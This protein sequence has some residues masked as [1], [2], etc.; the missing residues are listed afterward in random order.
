MQFRRREKYGRSYF[1]Q[2]ILVS[3]SSLGDLAYFCLFLLLL[4][5]ELFDKWFLAILYFTIGAAG[6]IVSN[7][8]MV[9]GE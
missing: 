2:V 7:V 4:S 1:F 6:A 3:E 9:V 5:I 8:W